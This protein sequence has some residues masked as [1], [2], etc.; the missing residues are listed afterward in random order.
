[1]KRAPDGNIGLTLQ[2]IREKNLQPGLIKQGKLLML[3]DIHHQIDIA[4]SP[5]LPARCR[6]E[7]VQR[8]R[9]TRANFRRMILQNSND[10]I[11]IHP[12]NMAINADLLNR[13]RLGEVAG[14]VHIGA[15]GDRRVIGQQ[16][17]RH[18]IEDGGYE[19]IDLR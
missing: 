12:H 6:S 9:P 18:R 15:F 4:G 1:M 16:L 14:L 8:V 7:Q 3:V 11:F 2:H 13:H 17:H 5:R 19:V 10:L